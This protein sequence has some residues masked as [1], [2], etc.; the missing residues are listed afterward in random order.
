MNLPQPPK[1]GTIK[2]DSNVSAWLY[3]A[4]KVCRLSD[5]PKTDWSTFASTLL[6]NA[7]QTLFSTAC[8]TSPQALEDFHEW[9]SFTEWC[10]LNLHFATHSTQAK[11]AISNLKQIS[12]V[13]VY[14]SAFNTLAC[15]AGNEGIHIFW[16]YQG[17]KPIIATT[18][19]L[20]PLTKAEHTDLHAP[21]AAV[22]VEDTR[23]LGLAGPPQLGCQQDLSTAQEGK[24]C[25]PDTNI[26]T[27]V[28]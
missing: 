4:G 17:L 20:D 23:V 27:M 6:E 12:T 22:A 9:D 3:K 10:E 11:I 24:V 5:Y 26:T 14:R 8:K 2:V 7:P 16:W 1:F 15:H 18:P 28:Y 13:S 25:S 21:N 19:A